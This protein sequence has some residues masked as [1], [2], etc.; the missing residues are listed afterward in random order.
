MM[1]ECT[2]NKTR[3]TY[4]RVCVEISYGCSFPSL[5]PLWIDGVH[6]MDFLVEYQWKPS[7]CIKCCSFG[8]KASSCSVK[9]VKKKAHRMHKK[10]QQLSKSV[11]MGNGNIMNIVNPVNKINTS[12]EENFS[13]ENGAR[14]Y[15]E[16]LEVTSPSMNDQSNLSNG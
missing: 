15:D 7:K 1:D 11:E 6:V 3:L 9:G 14:D 4:S 12:V 13:A 2:K 8:H 10:N 16:V 5:I